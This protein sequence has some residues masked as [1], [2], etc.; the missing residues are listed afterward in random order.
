ML[1]SATLSSVRLA[2][3]MRPGV[4]EGGGGVR[5]GVDGGRTGKRRE[6]GYLGGMRDRGDERDR[7]KERGY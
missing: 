1:F 4:R 3:N 2:R 5:E 7:G 6:Q